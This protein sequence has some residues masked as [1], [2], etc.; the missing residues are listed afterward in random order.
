MRDLAGRRAAVPGAESAKL[1]A[2]S[3][4]GVRDDLGA[5]AIF[6]PAELLSAW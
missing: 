2:V 1:L 4:A 3:R 5:D 6:G